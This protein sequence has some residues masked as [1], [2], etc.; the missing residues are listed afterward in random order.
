MSGDCIIP[1]KLSKPDQ[2]FGPKKH[3]ISV[4]SRLDRVLGLQGPPTDG[5]YGALEM[6]NNVPDWVARERVS[7]PPP[8][9]LD[10][11]MMA[12]CTES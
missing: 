12:P 4:D 9:P 8:A 7:R 11:A 2:R 3:V 6:M 1:S 5:P 10:T